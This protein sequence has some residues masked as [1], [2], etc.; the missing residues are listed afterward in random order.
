MKTIL[1]YS[2]IFYLLGMKLGT[3]VEQIRRWIVP[4]K[5]SISLQEESP[6]KEPTE[7]RTFY[8]RSGVLHELSGRTAKDS[9]LLGMRFS[10]TSIPAAIED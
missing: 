6:A 8:V 10:K 1:L 7:A 3:T 2:S 4:D 5:Q 9:S